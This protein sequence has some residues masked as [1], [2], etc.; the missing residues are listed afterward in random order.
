MRIIVLDSDTLD[1]D[2]TAWSDLRQLGELELYGHTPHEPSVLIDRIKGCEAVFT[3]K[4]PLSSEVLEASPT[5]KF[6]GV[7]ATGYNIIDIEAAKRLGKTV[8]N[9]PGYGTSTTAQHAVALG[10]ELCN[11]VAI[12]SESVHSGEWISSKHFSYW[13]QAPLELESMTVGIVGFGTIGR[14]VGATYH[15][16][17]ARVIASARTPRNTPDWEGFEW[18]SNEELF[19]QSDLVSLH[20]PQTPEMTG[21]VNAER[22]STMKTGALFVNTARGGLVDEAALASALRNGELGGA[23]LDVLTV[24]PMA[25]DCPLIGAPNCLI[26]PHIAWASEPARRRLLQASV[27]NLIAFQNNSPV[28]VVSV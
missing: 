22:L 26:T 23:A 11:Q 2:Q 6:V 13:K 15:A 24:E 18:V 4:V 8:C 28:N 1:F 7:L 17:G 21:F 14:R 25:K 5:L 16:L 19:E 27:D 20:C 10:L 12:H 3:N 9:V